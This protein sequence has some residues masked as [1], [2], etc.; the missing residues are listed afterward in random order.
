MLDVIKKLAAPVILV[1]RPGLGTI[2]HS[3]LSLHRL[4]HAGIEVLGIVFNQAQPGCPGYIE[5]DNIAAVAGYGNVHVLGSLPF[6]PGLEKLRRSPPAFLKWA[7]SNLCIQTLC[8][9]RP[10][11]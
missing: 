1:A 7:K 3:L 4:R 2:N 8:P 5:K 6:V 11:T 9:P 10:E